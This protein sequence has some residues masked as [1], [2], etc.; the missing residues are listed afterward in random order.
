VDGICREPV[1]GVLGWR[2]RGR[3]ASRFVPVSEAAG[4]CS[5]LRHD[6]RQ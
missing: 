1:A 5:V 2:R 4:V 6:R 3:G